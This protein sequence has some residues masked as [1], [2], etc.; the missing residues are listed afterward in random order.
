MRS[1]TGYSGGGIT[2]SVV[3]LAAALVA[4]APMASAA[5]PVES[6]QELDRL[7][8]LGS[9]QPDTDDV[10]KQREYHEER[11]QAVHQVYEVALPQLHDEV[12]DY[13]RV[14]GLLMISGFGAYRPHS[15]GPAIRFRNPTMP[16][17]DI[18]EQQAHDL[19]AQIRM[20]TVQVR[21]GF[22]PA[23]RIDYDRNFCPETDRTD[24]EHQLEVDLL[25]VRLVDRERSRDS[26][27][28]LIDTYHTRQ[29]HRWTLIHNNLPAPSLDI[30]HMQWRRE[31]DDWEA[32]PPQS[33]VLDS[34]TSSLAVAME[35]AMFPCYVR[36]LARNATLQGAVV[37]ELSLH[38][39]GIADIGFLMDTIQTVPMRQCIVDRISELDG[40]DEV[41]DQQPVDA[42]KATVLMR[43]R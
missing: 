37:L 42:L 19:M 40:F 24:P 1:D 21:I 5:T 30:S 11:R 9:P 38:D 17:F 3:V 41:V 15:A 6:V 43:R 32:A 26:G 36:A 4:V 23:A 8:Q 31:G 16:R 14:S 22:I 20:G 39:D 12:M 28:E 34:M 2:A 33:E 10:D 7:C 35:R 29:G 25:Y 18:E 27:G 13:D